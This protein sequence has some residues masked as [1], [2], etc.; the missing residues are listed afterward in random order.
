MAGCGT[1]PSPAISFEVSTITTGGLAQQG[2]LADS[3][4]PEQQ[5]AF[6][7]GEEVAHDGDR[8]AHG[9][10]D[11]AGEPDDV[12]APV[13]QRG[14][15]VERFGDPGAIVGPEAAD[16]GDGEIDVLAGDRLLAER[17]RA[18]GVAC[19]GCSA[20]IEDDLEE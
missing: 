18:V 9:A 5:H 13:P 11:S 4:A 19:L 8:A 6:G 20:E 10:S 1:S 16:A 3:G 17:A 2:R 12:T 7:A 15:A 14:D